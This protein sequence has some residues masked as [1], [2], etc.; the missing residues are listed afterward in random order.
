MYLIQLGPVTY[1]KR[2]GQLFTLGEAWREIDGC[3]AARIVTE[4]GRIVLGA[5]LGGHWSR[6]ETVRRAA[7]SFLLACRNGSEPKAGV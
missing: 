4:S 7:V 2:G 6:R 5:T 1:A 3:G